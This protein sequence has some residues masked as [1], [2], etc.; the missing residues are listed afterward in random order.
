MKT[1][2][3]A[4]VILTSLAF[5]GCGG[6]QVAMYDEGKRTPSASVEVF[7]QGNKPTK[8]FKEIGE[9]SHHDYSGEDA[10]VMREL[11]KQ[12]KLAGADAIVMQSQEDTGYA[13]VPFG[14]SGNKQVWKAIMVVYQ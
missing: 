13:F 1:L 5:F 9:I 3:L 11:I 7:R 6:P 4:V 2:Q 14:R 12:A 10:R 8:A